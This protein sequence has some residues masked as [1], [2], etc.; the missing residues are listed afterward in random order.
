MFDPLDCAPEDNRPPFLLGDLRHALPHLAGSEARVAEAVDQGGD[1]VVAMGRLSM[2]QQGALDD[3]PHVQALDPLRRPVRRKLCGADPPHLFGVGLEKDAV[4]APSELVAHPILEAPR[5]WDR[6]DTRSGVAGQ[7]PDGLHKTEVPKCIRRLKRVGE[8]AVPVIDARQAISR[9]HLGTKDLGPEVLDLLVLREEAVAAD[10]EPIAVVLDRAG[11]PP[12]VAGVLFDHRDRD[13][14]LHQLIGGCEAGR[15]GAH[16]HDLPA[17]VLK[18]QSAH[19]VSTVRTGFPIGTCEGALVQRSLAPHLVDFDQGVAKT[20]DPIRLVHPN[21]P[22]APRQGI[23]PAPGDSAG[24]QRVQDRPL[25]HTKAGHDGHAESGEDLGL[26]SAS[27]APGDLASEMT[28][29]LPSDLDPLFTGLFTKAVDPRR[30]RSRTRLGSGALSQLDVGQ[31][32]QNEDLVT[33]RRYLGWA[34][35]PRVG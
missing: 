9:Q 11:K 24:N 27:H 5:I 19:R 6:R 7:A 2:W 28:L 33:V 25:R 14:V 20:L 1:D 29:S 16:D 18:C 12:D 23:A 10:V 34:G 31:S 8:K 13:L 15:A 21:E 3:E 32:A 35:E 4:E 22:Y 30:P 26:I 17:L